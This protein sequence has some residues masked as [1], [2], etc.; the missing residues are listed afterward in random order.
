MH[1]ANRYC[2]AI[3]QYTDG[4]NADDTEPMFVLTI[5]EKIKETRPKLC[6]VS[7]TVL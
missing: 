2:W 4:E 3:A 5:L 1:L 7:V 6:Q